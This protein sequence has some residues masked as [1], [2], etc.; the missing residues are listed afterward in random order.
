VG[1][2]GT[3]RDIQLVEDVGD[4]AL[5]GLSAQ[6]ELARNDFVAVALGQGLQLIER[7]LSE[8]NQP[9]RAL[10]ER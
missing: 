10:L 9:K 8:R 3:R 7:A 4:V 5:H 1:G 6:P 2:L